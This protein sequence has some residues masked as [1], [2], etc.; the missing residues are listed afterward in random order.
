MSTFADKFLE[1]F[2]DFDDTPPPT[3]TNDTSTATTTT[4]TT[5][6]VN[7]NDD[8]QD[9]INNNDNEINVGDLD[10]LMLTD[11]ML[12]K[13]QNELISKLK[14]QPIEQ[15]AKLSTSNKLL[16]LMKRVDEQMSQ[17]LPEK[18]VK[19]LQSGKEHQLIIECNTMVQEIQH[20]IYL[21]HKYIKEKYSKKF[22]ELES[23][24]HNPLDY[25]NVVKRIR[26]ENDLKNIELGD[27]LPRSTIMVLVVTL[28]STTGKNLDEKEMDKVLNACDMAIQLD[29]TKKKVLTYLESRMTYIAP[30]IS[31]LLGGNIASKLIGIAGSIQKLSMIPA[32]HLQTLG[33]DKTTLSGLSGVSNKKFQSGLIS[34]CDLVKQ[35]PLALKIKA[36]RI[37]TGRVSLAARIDAQQDS[38]LYGEMGRK[39]RDEIMEKIE[40][41]QEP[42]PPKLDKA[43]PAPDDTKK[44]KRG[45]Q[46][47]MAFAVEEKTIGD[48][49][50]GM[51][52]IGGETGKLRLHAQDKGILKKK[53]LEQK[54]YGSGTATGTTTAAS[55]M[56]GLQSVA[57]TPAQ[58]LLLSITQND[59]E[60]QLANKT[61]KYFGSNSLKRKSEE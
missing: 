22:P 13:K 57:I 23:S 39:Y 1:D 8:D 5:T 9:M 44:K 43:L 52:M 14:D 12:E 47:R 27:L 56:S 17:A 34:Q 28:S 51:G 26:N 24:V 46:N 4:T 49:G 55:S 61:E 15:V 60:A 20:E 50:V 2:N 29:E 25:I 53:K 32:G 38:S 31:I 3:T 19:T 21:I 7:N 58:G 40:K 18:G 45:A 48:T 41:L 11:E 54:N 36:L 35:A 6:G 33:A 37:L 59:R 42:P 16:S 10:D 30:N